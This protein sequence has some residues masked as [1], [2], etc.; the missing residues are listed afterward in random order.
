M[1]NTKV[2]AS[3]KLTHPSRTDLLVPA[4]GWQFCRFGGSA[5]MSIFQ[6]LYTSKAQQ[7]LAKSDLDAILRTAQHNNAKTD[8]TGFLIFD[9]AHFIQL[10]E[11]QR[12]HV[13]TVYRLIESDRRHYSVEPLLQDVKPARSL[14]NWAM[15][16]TRLD[17]EGRRQSGGS[18][19]M[20]NAR[21]IASLLKQNATPMRLIISDFLTSA[22]AKNT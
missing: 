5:S 1:F 3:D 17:R 16:Y 6:L 10:L 8:V 11:G 20:S 15:A 12:S 19:D 7:G 14:S 21:E 22:F 18:M 2:L 9:G 13:E 4:G